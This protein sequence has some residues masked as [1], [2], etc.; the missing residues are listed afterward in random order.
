MEAKREYK[1]ESAVELKNKYCQAKRK[2]NLKIGNKRDGKL[3]GQDV[4]CAVDVGTKRAHVKVITNERN[5]STS[6]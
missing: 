2:G 5:S 4:R 1:Q 3:Q 6:L